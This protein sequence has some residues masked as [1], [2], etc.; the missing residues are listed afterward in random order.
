MSDE[1]DNN[2][3]LLTQSNLNNRNSNIKNE[4]NNSDLNINKNSIFNSKLE[5]TNNINQKKFFF[6]KTDNNSD[7]NSFKERLSDVI[8][9]KHVNIDKLNLYHIIFFL[10]G[11]NFMLLLIYLYCNGLDNFILLCLFLMQLT[12]F[13]LNIFTL[14]KKLK[15]SENGMRIFTFF[16]STIIYSILFYRTGIYD[17]ISLICFGFLKILI[18]LIYFKKKSEAYKWCYVIFLGAVGIIFNY[19][20]VENIVLLLMLIAGTS[21]MTNEEY[22]KEN[23]MLIFIFNSFLLTILFYLSNG[24]YSPITFI[25]YSIIEVN[26]LKKI[27]NFRKISCV[28]KTFYLEVLFILIFTIGFWVCDGFY[29]KKDTIIFLNNFNLIILSAFNKIIFV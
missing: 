27:R 11:S 29:Y 6:D 7:D 20:D 3:N 22:K 19:D 21:T 18:E 9:L 17:I 28:R 8:S 4:L 16:S 13:L 25:L 1:N 14:I 15:V 10:F 2:Y 26:I 5:E 24:F 12:D 23:L